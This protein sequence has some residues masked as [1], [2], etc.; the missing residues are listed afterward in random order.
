MPKVEPSKEDLEGL[1]RGYYLTLEMLHHISGVNTRLLNF[2]LFIIYFLKNSLV[3][4]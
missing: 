1:F 3:E 2:Y 4:N